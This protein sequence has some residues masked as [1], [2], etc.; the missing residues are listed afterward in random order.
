VVAGSPQQTALV[1]GRYTNNQ[2]LFQIPGEAIVDIIGPV[3][4]AAGTL[5]W[6]ALVTDRAN[7]R[8]TPIS[9]LT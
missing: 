4:T 1:I 3:E 6:A 5:G 9:H 8:R 7:Y 2:T